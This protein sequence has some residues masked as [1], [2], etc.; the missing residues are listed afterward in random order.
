MKVSKLK[1]FS[2]KIKVFLKKRRTKIVSLIS[3]LKTS[4]AKRRKAKLESELP[5]SKLYTF[6]FWIIEALLAGLGLN[7]MLWQLLGFKF[8]IGTVIAW[9]V[10][11]YFVTAEFPQVIFNCKRGV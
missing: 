6:T 3:K 5:P 8:S 9:S 11:Y 2:E 4:L 7:F 1:K 10:A